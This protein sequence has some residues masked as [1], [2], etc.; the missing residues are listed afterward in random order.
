MNSAKFKMPSKTYKIFSSLI[1]QLKQNSTIISIA[2]CGSWVR[3]SAHPKSDIDI[4]IVSDDSNLS[5]IYGIHDVVKKIYV[6]LILSPH[7]AFHR[8]KNLYEKASILPDAKLIYTRCD[9]CKRIFSK[10]KGNYNLTLGEGENILFHLKHIKEKI[11]SSNDFIARRILISKFVYFVTLCFQRWSNEAILGELQG[12]NSIRKN[13]PTIYRNLK[14]LILKPKSTPQKAVSA[15]ITEFENLR[16]DIKPPFVEIRDLI[17][18]VNYKPLSE[19]ERK[20]A[21]SFWSEIVKDF[22]DNEKGKHP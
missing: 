3:N 12:L 11:I 14:Y 22:K 17:T 8:E 13:S 6:D 10:L 5:K 19:K 18:P 16:Q 2:L 4:F 20:Y 1:K 9:I 21:H 7:E 15:I